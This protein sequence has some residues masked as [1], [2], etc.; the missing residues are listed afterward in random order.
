MVFQ[1]PSL[2]P[3][4]QMHPAGKWVQESALSIL[5]VSVAGSP[6]N[7]FASAITWTAAEQ[8]AW[9][10]CSEPA[11]HPPYCPG[12]KYI[13]GGYGGEGIAGGGDGG[14]GGA[15]SGPHSQIVSD[16]LP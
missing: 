2:V 6:V 1:R 9:D 10:T 5:Y 7:P 3:E 14:A 8:S 12:E 13:R 16:V 11:G 4:D 15:N